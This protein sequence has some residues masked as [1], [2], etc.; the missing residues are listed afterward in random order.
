MCKLLRSVIIDNDETV[1]CRKVHFI[2]NVKK[3]SNSTIGKPVISGDI[4]VTLFYTLVSYPSTILDDERKTTIR[5]CYS[6]T[7]K[8]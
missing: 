6:L 5:D 8:F 1:R 7:N 2:S 4:S 3:K